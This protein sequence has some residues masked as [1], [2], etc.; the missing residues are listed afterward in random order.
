MA[1]QGFSIEDLPTSFVAILVG[2]LSASLAL[3]WGR[4]KSKHWTYCLAFVSPIAISWSLAWS[5]VWFQG[6]DPSEYAGWWL[7]D[8]VPWSA[9]GLVG[10]FGVVLIVRNFRAAGTGGDQ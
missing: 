8:V 3:L 5:P 6:R 4:L 1:S 7:L 10:S 2:L 9:A